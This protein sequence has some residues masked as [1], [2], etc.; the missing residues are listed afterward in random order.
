MIRDRGALP[1]GLK[2]CTKMLLVNLKKLTAF[3]LR[4]MKNYDKIT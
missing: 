1:C 4:K 3:L 2:N